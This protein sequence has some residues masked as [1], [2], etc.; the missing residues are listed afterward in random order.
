MEKGRLG[1]EPPQFSTLPPP[2]VIKSKRAGT[3]AE[4][5]EVARQYE[6]EK[7]KRFMAAAKAGLFMGY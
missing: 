2:A 7:G 3:N 5:E 4:R 1:L 6:T